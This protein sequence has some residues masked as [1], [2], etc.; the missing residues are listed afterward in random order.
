MIHALK[1]PVGIINSI[2]DAL[3]EPQIVHRNL[4]VNIPHRL[5]KTSKPLAHPSNCL[6]L[7]LNIITHR[8]NLVNILLKSYRDLKQQRSWLR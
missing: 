7:P 1:V 2:E 4:V 8:Q 5:N 3:A 6:I